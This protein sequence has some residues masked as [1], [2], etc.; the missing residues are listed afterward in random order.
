M[1]KIAAVS[2]LA[3]SRVSQ[4]LAD[5]VKRG[6]AMGALVAIFFMWGP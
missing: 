6:L 3:L 1:Q 2:D 4:L 5:D